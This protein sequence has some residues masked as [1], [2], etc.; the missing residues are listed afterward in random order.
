[1]LV[2]C[3]L[4]QG[5]RVGL[6][7]VTWAILAIVVLSL[8]YLHREAI[9]WGN[10]PGP[11]SLTSPTGKK[12]GSDPEREPYPGL[13]GWSFF[14]GTAR[15]A[16]MTLLLGVFIFLIMP[17]SNS[18][19][20]PPRGT[21]AP[22]SMTGFSDEVRL[23][24]MGEILENDT[25]V[26]TV[27]ML[28]GG[29]RVQPDEESLRW[30]GVTLTRYRD[31]RWRRDR[32]EVQVGSP[33]AFRSSSGPLLEQRI[34]ME[35]TADRVIFALRPIVKLDVHPEGMISMNSNDGT[36]I[37][38]VDRRARRLAGGLR[39]TARWTTSFIRRPIRARSRCRR[40]RTTS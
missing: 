1:M 26:F 4:S 40:E 33:P 12:G 16:S 29:R 8:F 32:D 17:R 21:I 24:Q 23:G 22:R 34:R 30:R 9:R 31:G 25:V 36:L 10:A 2:G 39:T 35:E 11:S 5:D 3:F 28:Q 7:L 14:L 18:R 37:R 19:A 38:E 27:E 13:F 15:A 20:Q 6:L